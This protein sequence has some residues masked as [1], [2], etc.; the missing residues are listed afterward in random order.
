VDVLEGEAD[1]DNPLW[2]APNLLATPHI[3]SA[4]EDALQDIRR[5]TED[6]LVSYLLRGYPRY[7]A[8]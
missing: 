5:M 4:T 3:A 8:F 7:P 6:N 1:P 2:N